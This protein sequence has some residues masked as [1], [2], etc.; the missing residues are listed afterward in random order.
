MSCLTLQ[1]VGKKTLSCL[2]VF[3][4]NPHD[5]VTALLGHYTGC[6]GLCP[7]VHTSEITRDI[8]ARSR[9]PNGSQ[10]PC[11]R[12]RVQCLRLS[13]EKPA[14]AAPSLARQGFNGHCKADNNSSLLRLTL[15]RDL[16]KVNA[17]CDLSLS[18]LC[19]EAQKCSESR[20]LDPPEALVLS[21]S[22]L[23]RSTRS[24]HFSQ[25]N[26]ISLR[27]HDELL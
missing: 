22:S 12:W 5:S 21:C 25:H 18:D 24:Q 20:P 13:G 1:E 9:R 11:A 2:A 26:S 15:S 4:R 19:G 7:I 27:S 14:K 16:Q 10:C 6:A 23:L 3:E 8:Q 17:F